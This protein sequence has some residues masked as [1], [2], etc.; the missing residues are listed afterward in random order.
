[1]QEP[2]D[3][4]IDI[5]TT[6]MATDIDTGIVSTTPEEMVRGQEEDHLE[7]GGSEIDTNSNDTEEIRSSEP[8]PEL[9]KRQCRRPAKFADYV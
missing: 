9:P 4:D 2:L 6:S 5:A 1:M 3:E 7:T 8:W